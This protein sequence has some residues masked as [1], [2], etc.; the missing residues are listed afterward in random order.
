MSNKPSARILTKCND[1]LQTALITL[2]ANEELTII[3]T[4]RVTGPEPTMPDP[5]DYPTRVEY[6]KACIELRK[7]FIKRETEATITALGKLSLNVSQPEVSRV[8]V[9][10]GAKKH[11]LKALR[12]DG[13]EHASLNEQLT[14]LSSD[15]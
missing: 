10:S 7:E 14:L 6:R 3:A 5:K 15:K 8:I 4:L 9:I 2:S 12:L 11:I 1:K 13:I